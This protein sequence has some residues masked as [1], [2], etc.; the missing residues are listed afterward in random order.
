MTPAAQARDVDLDEFR[1]GTEARIAELREQR[2]R[3]APEALTNTAAAKRLATIEA[4]LAAAEQALERVDL[5]A[6]ETDRR[7]IEAREQAEAQARAEGLQRAQE[8]QRDRELAAVEVDTAART[9]AEALQRWDAIAA[10]QERAVRQA[11]WSSVTAQAVRPRPHMVEDAL[12]MALF[13]ARCPRGIVRI[14]P[15]ATGAGVVSLA[16]GDARAVRTN[17]DNRSSDG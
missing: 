8:L 7:E 10:E 6:A 1:A 17:D 13:D 11:G 2:Q 9:F 15:P 16:D 3:L 4:D 5:A 14:E 12:R